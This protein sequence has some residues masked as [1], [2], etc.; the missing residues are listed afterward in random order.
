[1]AILTEAL[2]RQIVKEINETQEE[3]RRGLAQRRHDI[4]HDGGKRFLIEAIRGEFGEDSVREMRIAPINVL[5]PIVNRRSAIYRNGPVRT[6]E[7]ES[8]QALVDAYTQELDVDNVMHKAHKYF[9]LF[10]NTAIYAIPKQGL[11]GLEVVPPFLYSISP[12]KLNKTE[13]DIWVFSAFLEGGQIAPTRS[14]GPATGKQQFE[15][16]QGYRTRP[17]AVASE[18][19]ETDTMRRQYIFWT[20]EM[21]V[22]TDEKGNWLK[23]DPEREMEQFVNPLGAAPVV[24]DYQWHIV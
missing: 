15:K 18:E 10:A 9:N 22:T 6:T 4:Y 5:K 11:M 14:V 17:D 24:K 13:I 19:I 23:L 16:N 20:D 2:T 12:N 3:T 8:D 1:M 7:L 21:H